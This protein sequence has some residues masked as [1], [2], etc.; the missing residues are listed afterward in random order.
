M[1]K[2]QCTYRYCENTSTLYLHSDINLYYTHDVF[3][4]FLNKNLLYATICVH[5]QCIIIQ[6]IFMFQIF[7]LVFGYN[8][9]SPATEKY[10]ERDVLFS[11]EKWLK[12][13]NEKQNWFFT[14]NI[15]HNTHYN[16]VSI[17]SLQ[18]ALYA[19][20]YPFHFWFY[21]HNQFQSAQYTSC[22]RAFQQ[23]ALI[24]NILKTYEL[25]V[26]NRQS[27]IFFYC[28]RSNTSI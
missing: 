18:L 6:I 17:W 20:L 13:T 19:F 14:L 10:G 12:K 3:I 27:T 4:S 5:I 25:W 16:I 2:L 23:Y 8:I 7:F 21:D 11:T 9:L 26:D 24:R 22:S 15:T 28:I 1:Y